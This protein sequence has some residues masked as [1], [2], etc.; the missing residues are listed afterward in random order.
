ME[1]GT[2]E[3]G[4]ETN[5][6]VSRDVNYIDLERSG[7]SSWSEEVSVSDFFPDLHLPITY[8]YEQP[9]AIAMK[10]K[11]TCWRMHPRGEYIAL[12]T[13]DCLTVD[14]RLCRNKA[15]PGTQSCRASRIG[16]VSRCLWQKLN[17]RE[18]KGQGADGSGYTLASN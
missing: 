11:A 12:L 14:G 8:I 2:R 9:M 13:C 10:S 4:Q 17:H 3:R 15:V 5:L 7:T 1:N 16:E 18:K 6:S